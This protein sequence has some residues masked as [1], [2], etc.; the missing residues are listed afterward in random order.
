VRLTVQRCATLVAMSVAI[1]T[2]KLD[3]A[4]AQTEEAYLIPL[5]EI[6]P[7]S[8]ADDAAQWLEKYTIFGWVKVLL[9]FGY[10]DDFS[11]CRELIDLYKARYPAA[12]YRC[13]NAN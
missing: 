9:V 5:V 2:G 1:L 12:N 13:S 3:L 10:G 8:D 11:A 7:R 4:H 6:M